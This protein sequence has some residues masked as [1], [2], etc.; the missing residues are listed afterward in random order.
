ML[1]KKLELLRKTFLSYFGIKPL[2]L[3]EVQTSNPNS[4]YFQKKQKKVIKLFKS[5]RKAN[6]KIKIQVFFF[7]LVFYKKKLFLPYPQNF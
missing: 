6:E 1:K 5:D 2:I 3:I 7:S 4:N